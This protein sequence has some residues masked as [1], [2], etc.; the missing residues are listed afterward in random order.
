MLAI[1]ERIDIQIDRE[2]VLR[3]LGYQAGHKVPARILSLV[4][5][6]IQNASQ[7]I[8][9]QHSF[10]IRN[11]EG[12]EGDKV[13]FGDVTFESRIIAQLMQRCQKAAVFAVTIGGSLEGQV[14][15]LADEGRVLEAAIMDAV[16]SDAAEKAATAVQGRVREIAN[17]QGLGISSRFSPGYCD[18]DIG[19]QTMVFHA[20]NGRSAGIRLTD[21]CL[22]VPRKSVSGVIGM[23]PHGGE[24]ERWSPCQSCKRRNCPGRR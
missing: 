8:E 13:F 4:D 18:W 15:Q 9:P 5:R 16:G 22:M 7:L 6:H 14:R 11:T 10:V 19:Q 3:Y 20:M 24:L 17:A 2:E 23:S 12:V 1:D 21:S